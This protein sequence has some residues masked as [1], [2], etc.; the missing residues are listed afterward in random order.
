MCLKTPSLLTVCTPQLQCFRS[1]ILHDRYVQVALLFCEMHRQYLQYYEPQNLQI[2]VVIQNFL[3]DSVKKIVSYLVRFMWHKRT[4]V[5]HCFFST[6]LK[7]NAPMW[8][9]SPK[10]ICYMFDVVKL[11]S[12]CYN[13]VFLISKKMTAKAPVSNTVKHIS[14]G[15]HT[16]AR[17]RLAFVTYLLQ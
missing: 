12:L 3:S 9:G 14:G 16:L 5:W 13:M 4:F 6:P 7:F 17:A 2:C 15:T 11:E 10:D 8:R 1:C